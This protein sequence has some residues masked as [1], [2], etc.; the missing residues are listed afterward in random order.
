MATVVV[1]GGAAGMIS[2][3]YCAL[4]GEKTLLLEQNHKLGK[5]LYITGKGRCNVT[6][7]CEVTEFLSNVVTNAR[8]MQGAIWSFSPADMMDFLQEG[9]LAIKTER[10]NRVFPLSD[11][12]S[13]VIKFLERKMLSVG[14]E[15]MLEC[16]VTD[17]IADENGV[18]GVETS[19]GYIECERVIV[20]TGGKSYTSTG[21][22][23]D[24][25]KFAKKFGHTVLPLRS[26][27]CGLDCK[28]NSFTSLAGLSL[29]NIAITVYK[30]GKSIYTDFGEL[31]FT[32]T[33]VSGPVIISASSYISKEGAGE[34]EIS[35]DLKPALDEKTLDAR[36]LR[37]FNQFKNKCLKNAMVELLPKSLIPEVI[38]HSGVNAE[39]NVSEL[40]AV[41]RKKILNALKGLRYKILRLRPLE[42]CIVTGGG[43]NVKE[44]NPKTMESKL[45]KG[46]YFAGE[47][48]DV[49][50]L[51]G[52]FNL[53]CAF[54]M[55]YLAGNALKKI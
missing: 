44:I 26:A 50:A 55:G 48:L 10:G 16:V 4:N 38:F 46:L 34:Y 15:I 5:K 41:N 7:D 9:G 37:D 49:D 18:K 43:V 39:I 52:G 47:V 36:L 28:G 20:C 54:S 11:K 3:Y 22:T 42:E 25:Y 35:I 40:T 21:S 53:Q 51:T 12:S 24:G 33:G 31:L 8:F 1:G 19:K 29:K 45:V 17:I 32:H 6:N 13:D 30:N 14:V 23:G 2:A 27:L